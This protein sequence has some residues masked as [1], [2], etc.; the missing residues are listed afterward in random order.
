[1]RLHLHWNIFF[2]KFTDL[3]WIVSASVLT[4]PTMWNV[5]VKQNLTFYFQ[6][7]LTFTCYTLKVNVICCQTKDQHH[8]LEGKQNFI[9][10]LNGLVGSLFH[11]ELHTIYSYQCK[12]CKIEHSLLVTVDMRHR[13]NHWV[14]CWET[15]EEFSLTD[16]QRFWNSQPPQHEAQSEV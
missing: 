12:S 10:L 1:M 16:N 8:H 13:T 11:W 5:W 6:R 14:C 2:D 15:A 7:V 9:H 4:S 3:H